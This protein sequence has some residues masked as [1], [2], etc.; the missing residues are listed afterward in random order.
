MMNAITEIG[1]LYISQS[2]WHNLTFLQLGI[3]IV[4]EPIIKLEIKDVSISQ[5]QNFKIFVG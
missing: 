5:G 4:I 1:A 2:T 3:N